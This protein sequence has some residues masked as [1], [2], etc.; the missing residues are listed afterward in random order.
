M[1]TVKLPGEVI[2]TRVF[3]N[4]DDALDCA[5]TLTMDGHTATI[6]DYGTGRHLATVNA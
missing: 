6:R 2:S 4:Y 5:N 1:F 3:D